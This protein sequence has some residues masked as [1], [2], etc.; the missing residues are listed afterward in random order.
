MAPPTAASLDIQKTWRF[1]RAVGRGPR[2]LEDNRSCLCLCTCQVKVHVPGATF[3]CCPELS[4]LGPTPGE[5]ELP[6]NLQVLSMTLDLARHDESDREGSRALSL[7]PS[8]MLGP[9][10]TA[11][12]SKR[13]KFF[14]ERHV[15]GGAPSL[16]AANPENGGPSTTSPANPYELSRRSWCRQLA[17]LSASLQNSI[18]P[19]LLFLAQ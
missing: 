7:N 18:F 8:E 6:Y 19:L 15:V 13:K 2:P 5:S 10:Q 17:P 1:P 4:Q 16:G 9:S 12:D 3:A 11:T 14:K